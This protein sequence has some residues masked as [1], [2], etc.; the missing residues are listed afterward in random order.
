MHDYYSLSPH[1]HLIAPDGRFVGE[2]LF[3]S[4]QALLDGNYAKQHP[5]SLAGWQ[6]ENR[7][8]LVGASRVIVPT[9]DVDR[10]LRANIPSIQTIIAAHPADDRRWRAIAVAFQRDSALR[11]CILGVVLP[12]KGVEILSACARLARANHDPIEFHVIGTTD[13]NRELLDLGVRISGPYTQE[14]LP[15]LLRGCGPHVLWYPAQ[16]PET[17]SYT[18]SEGLQSG[19]PL[20]V[21][22]LG[23]FPERVGARPWTW[24]REWNLEPEEW[25]DFFLSIRAENFANGAAPEPLGTPWD[26][27]DQFY[28]GEYLAWATEERSAA[29]ETNLLRTA[30]E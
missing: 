8:L 16:C 11:I 12:H 21:P 20:V 17:F 18:L 6:A 22:N 7:W 19:L 27:T 9:R 1:P 30:A 13:R 25:I 14:D 15:H 3:A 26:V 23:A 24:V 10:R 29:D 28:H 5:A 2:D 4:A